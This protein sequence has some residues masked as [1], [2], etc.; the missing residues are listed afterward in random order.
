MGIAEYL[1]E[2]E[3]EKTRAEREKTRAEREKVKRER[4]KRIQER[5]KTKEK[6]RITAIK[7]KEEGVDIKII[8]KATGLSLA[9]I[10]KLWGNTIPNKNIWFPILGGSFFYIC[11]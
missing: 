7:L 6:E 2:Q 5:E 4:L 3:R 10:E 8:A 11:Q 1:L 9:E